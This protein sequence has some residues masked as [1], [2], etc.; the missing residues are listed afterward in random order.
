MPDLAADPDPDFID[1]AAL[2]SLLT[3]PAPDQAE[4]TDLLAI[5]LAKEPLTVAQTARLCLVTDPAL[6]TKIHEAARRLKREVYG[7][8]PTKALGQCVIALELANIPKTNQG[9]V[10]KR[11]EAIRAGTARDLY[12]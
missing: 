5:S 12:V 8:A 3:R 11:L 1:D 10:R 6:V 2:E 9:A 4:V 7:S